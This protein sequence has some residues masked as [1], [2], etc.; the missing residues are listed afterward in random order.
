MN[1][2]FTLG[3]PHAAAAFAAMIG[4]MAVDSVELPAQPLE[5]GLYSNGNKAYCWR[6]FADWQ[7]VLDDLVNVI[8]MLPTLRAKFQTYSSLVASIQVPAGKSLVDAASDIIGTGADAAFNNVNINIARTQVLYKA[9]I[10]LDV[11]DPTVV[12]LNRPASLLIT[13]L[14]P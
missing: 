4:G 14:Y 12:I 8:D 6:V 2:E 11:D 5:W 3:L 1:E 9:A 10:V 7:A 13:K